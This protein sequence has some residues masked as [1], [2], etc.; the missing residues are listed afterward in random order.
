ME[1]GLMLRH[2][3][4]LGLAVATFAPHALDAQQVQ[5]EADPGVK[6]TR[7][8]DNAEVRVSRLE[9]QPGA[10][11][12]VHTHDDVEF[13]LWIPFD[14]ELQITMG[15]DGRPVAATLGQAFFLR[16]GTAHGF[17]NVGTRPAGVFEV[18]VKKPATAGGLAS[19]GLPIVK[20]VLNDA[21]LR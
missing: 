21:V 17:T 5:A 18:F 6:L 2:V 13:H 14:G 8:I 3:A 11:R 10:A 4:V 1:V 15:S 19:L 16:R 12:R 9:L 20:D 7:L